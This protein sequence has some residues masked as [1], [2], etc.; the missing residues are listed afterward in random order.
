MYGCPENSQSALV[1][2]GDDLTDAHPLCAGSPNLE[3]FTI[4]LS[5]ALRLGELRQL[6]N[7]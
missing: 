7:L 4:Y 1:V 6:F 3:E 2:L 5:L